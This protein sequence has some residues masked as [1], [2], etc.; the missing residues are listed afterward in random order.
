M[1]SRIF[2]FA[3]A[4]ALAL[5]GVG[6]ARANEAILVAPPPAWAKPSPPVPAPADAS[7]LL[8]FERQDLQIRLDAAGQSQFQS[9]RVKLLHPQALQLGNV[10]LA[11]KPTSGAATV[12]SV[13]IHRGSQVIDVL[14]RAQFQILRR[15]DR[16]EQA[17]LSGVLTA[18]LQVPDLRVGDVLEVSFTIRDADPTLGGS[19]AGLWSLAEVPLPGHYRMALGWEPGQEP[20]TLISPA[21]QGA[22]SRGPDGVTIALT[23]PPPLPVPK[24]AP[25]RYAWQRVAE[26]SDFADWSAVAAKFAPLYAEAAKLAPNS[27]LKAEAARIRAAHPHEM[28]R[29]AAALK[30]VQQEVR[31]VYVGLGAGN[32][33]PAHA[34]ISWDRRFADCK[35]KTAMLLGLLA[36]LGI[37]AEPVLVNNSGADDGMDKRLPNPGYFDHVLVRATIAGKA[38]WLD[39]TLP[40]VAR[41]NLRPVVPYRWVLP[42]AKTGAKLK[43][44]VW[45][46]FPE[47]QQVTLYEI[48][49]RKG[50][51]APAKITTTTLT[52]G[53]KGLAEYAQFSALTPDQLTAAFRGNM[54]GG[55]FDAIDF[56]N[57]R[58]DE[59]NDASVLTISG[60]GP[61]DWDDD[62]DGRKSLSLPG[63]GFSPP[64]RRLREAGQDQSAPYFSEPLYDCDVTTIRFPSS[65]NDVEWSFN[66]SFINEMFGRVYYRSMLRKDG[67]IRMVRG[68]AVAMTEISP[69]MA[70]RD[71]A[72]LPNFDN[73]K[74]NIYFKPGEKNPLDPAKHIPVP[75]TWE[76]D[77]AR[78]FPPC[79]PT[80]EALNR[81][82]WTSLEPKPDSLPAFS[83]P[84]GDATHD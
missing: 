35:G 34:D 4:S 83:L 29:A 8:F 84:T 12:H 77:W 45:R 19:V 21:L 13:A 70:A 9:Y 46:P 48:D 58:Y 55:Q 74:A 57:W 1:R 42:I 63:G 59:D 15:E 62:G 24:D 71:N 10:M 73:S 52:R 33:S 81:A 67:T 61:V 65:T 79:L 36:E 51:D 41:P 22:L 78:P 50:F 16:L 39:G 72:R 69:A 49:A 68:T 76:I 23:N 5:V 27:P 75:A 2:A 66:T 18:S 25:P 53:I 38:R 37:A 80:Q 60:D 32:L 7:G 28:E 31:Y 82:G 20:R 14:D 26:Y 40:P 44:I 64:N 17:M 3:V 30:L 43:E 11:W 54:T 6:Q 56:V 47:P